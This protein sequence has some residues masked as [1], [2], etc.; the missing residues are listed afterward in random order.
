[1]NSNDKNMIIVRF[2][3]EDLSY[4]PAYWKTTFLQIID[5]L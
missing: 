4:N 1:M 3:K 5:Q 2:G